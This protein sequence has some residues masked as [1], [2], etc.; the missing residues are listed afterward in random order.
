MAPKID[1]NDLRLLLNVV[2][3]GGLTAA[4]AATG[5]PISTIS[6]RITTLEASAGK[7]LLTRTTRHVS[8]TETGGALLKHIRTIER[9]ARRAERVLDRSSQTRRTSGCL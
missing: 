8:L 9:A 1:L 6:R 5:V 7:L 4:A 2:E 3:H